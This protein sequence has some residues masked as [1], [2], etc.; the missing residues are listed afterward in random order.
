MLMTEQC[1]IDCGES[2]NMLQ[3]QHAQKM[4]RK[5]VPHSRQNYTTLPLHTAH[6][7]CDQVKTIYSQ[8]FE[9]GEV[10]IYSVKSFEWYQ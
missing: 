10:I 7:F 3:L 5:P 8:M 1:Q 9:R 4:L 6:I 2:E